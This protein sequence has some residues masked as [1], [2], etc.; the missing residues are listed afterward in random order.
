MSGIE[1]RAPTR[2]MNMVMASKHENVVGIGR[3]HASDSATPRY[4]DTGASNQ[5]ICRHP[6]RAL[7][8]DFI[9]LSAPLTSGV[10]NAMN[11]LEIQ[12]SAITRQVLSI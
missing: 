9:S 5:S 10:K 7:L 6:S 12:C 11:L 3:K 1:Q 4:C 2:S 8:E